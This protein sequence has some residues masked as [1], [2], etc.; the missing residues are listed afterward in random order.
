MTLVHIVLLRLKPDA[1]VTTIDDMYKAFRDLETQIPCILSLTVGPQDNLIYPGYKPRTQ[2]YTHGLVVHF[3]TA[4]DLQTYTVHP[5]HLSV[6]D[7]I[8]KPIS[9]AVLALDFMD[10]YVNDKDDISTVTT[11]VTKTVVKSPRSKIWKSFRH[12]SSTAMIPTVCL[13]AGIGLA[14]LVN[15]RKR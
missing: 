6:V 9:D 7:R 14:T 8:I 15:S 1:P 3:R 4:A 10:N 5:A 11:T 12:Y 2:G 13:F